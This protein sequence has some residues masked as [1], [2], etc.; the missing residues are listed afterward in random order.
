MQKLQ[1]DQLA[2]ENERLSNN[3]PQSVVTQQ[4][5]PRY[6]LTELLKLRGEVAVLRDENRLLRHRLPAEVPAT[7]GQTNEII[8]RPQFTVSYNPN[9][10][11]I[12]A[13]NSESMTWDFMPDS[14]DW[15]QITV[16]SR[17][18]PKDQQTYKKEL[19][20]RQE[21]RGDPAE[22]VAERLETIAGRDW[23]VLELRNANTRPP[24]T[25]TYYFLPTSNGHLSVFV[26]GEEADIPRH[27]ETIETFLGQIRIAN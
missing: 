25:E 27:R 4:E 13:S 5:L 6:Q 9:L 23:T 7:S 16:A 26:V 11:Y 10:W 22:L 19:L 21:L 1:L 20:D 8:S 24:R 14:S 15:V 3:A 2:A 12:K 18:E 17:T